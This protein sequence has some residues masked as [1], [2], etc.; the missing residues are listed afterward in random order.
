MTSFNEPGNCLIFVTLTDYGK[1]TIQTLDEEKIDCRLVDPLYD[2]THVMGSS[3]KLA[4][5]STCSRICQS[6]VTCANMTMGGQSCNCMLGTSKG[7][8]P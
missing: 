3:M 8:N 7:E 4:K 6:R 5:N 1:A 2:T